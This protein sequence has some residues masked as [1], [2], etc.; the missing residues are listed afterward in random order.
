MLKFA[1][2]RRE[3][4]FVE[5]QLYVSAI[6]RKPIDIV[7]SYGWSL[8]PGWHILQGLGLIDRIR[9]N[10]RAAEFGDVAAYAE[11]CPKVARQGADVGAAAAMN[12]DADGNR[13]LGHRSYWTNR[14]YEFS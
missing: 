2:K 8:S 11:L 5:S 4:A 6:V 13:S 9:A 3:N 12:P 14:T 7:V 1:M 10:G